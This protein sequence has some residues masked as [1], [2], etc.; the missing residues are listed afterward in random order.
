MAKNHMKDARKLHHW[1]MQIKTPVR[2]R[3]SPRRTANSKRRTTSNGIATPSQKYFH[4]F[5]EKVISEECN[6]AKEWLIRCR[7]PTARCPGSV[8]PG[9]RQRSSHP[10][11]A[12]KYTETWRPWITKCVNVEGSKQAGQ[13]PAQ[14][15][16]RHR[17][18]SAHLSTVPQRPHRSKHCDRKNGGEITPPSNT[19]LASL[20]QQG[21]CTGIWAKRETLRSLE[22]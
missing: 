3:F 19:Q 4:Y 1:E 21:H 13:F 11:L 5:P 16:T 9:K 10:H 12:D 15:F 6:L 20:C 14:C 17:P 7:E 18:R 8:V 2:Q 22:T